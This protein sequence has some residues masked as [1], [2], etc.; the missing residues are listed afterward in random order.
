MNDS[1]DMASLSLKFEF[2]EQPEKVWRAISIADYRKQ[3]LPDQQVLEVLRV[4]PVQ[5]LELL[6]EETMPPYER[7]IVTFSIRSNGNGGTAFGIVHRRQIV[8]PEAANSRGRMTM[9]LAA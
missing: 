7:S 4:S 1:E 3:W 8:I 5:E 2:E 9:M 6:V